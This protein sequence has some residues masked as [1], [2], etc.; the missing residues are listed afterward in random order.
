MFLVTGMANAQT[1][2]V[3]LEVGK[4]RIEVEVAANEQTR[5]FGLMYR[6]HLP[7]DQG[8]LFVFPYPIRICMWMKNT[9]TPLS[10]AFI[11][12]E[13]RVLNIED[14]VPQSEEDHCSVKMA[15]YALEMNRGWFAGHG[16]KAGDRIE[17]V[18]SLFA[19]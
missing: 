7:A 4:H 13:G 5:Q 1:Q 12:E 2:R 17:G 10:V 3:S 8:M 9:L 14:M 11:D 15:S 19:N 18:K 6:S 16:V